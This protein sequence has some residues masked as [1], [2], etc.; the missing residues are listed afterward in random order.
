MGALIARGR[1]V[2]AV[3]LAASVCA[4][5]LVAGAYG[6]FDRHGRETL[7]LGGS[8]DRVLSDRRGGVLLLGSFRGEGAGIVRLRAD[9][10]VD[11]SFAEKGFAEIGWSDAVVRRDGRILVV[12]SG[13][14][15]REPDASDL[16]VTRLRADGTI[17]SSFGEGGMVSVDLGRRL[18]EGTA[19]AMAPK[20]EI[21]IGGSSATT[22]F[23]RGGTDAVGVVGR[24]LPDGELDRRFAGDGL[25][26]V[27]AETVTGLANE[28][29]AG[30]LVA[31][32]GRFPVLEL[33]RLRRGGDLDRSFA[34][35]G[36]LSVRAPETGSLEDYFAPVDHIGML[37][38]GRFVVVGT[39][40]RKTRGHAFG[41]MAARFTADGTLDDSFGSGGYAAA[42]FQG[43][44]F[45]EAF[46]VGRNGGL[47]VAASTIAPESRGH[48]FG[49]I[50]FRPDGRLDR[51]VG[52]AG[53]VVPGFNGNAWARGLAFQSPRRVV[54]AGFLQ[55]RHRPNE[56]V[57]ARVT[58]G[59]SSVR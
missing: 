11:R 43:E 55:A 3:L 1:S 8:V 19:L 54:V 23:Q 2:V 45:P 47:V 13:E 38:S 32:G 20:G 44:T 50:F 51:T 40:S 7:R 16:T 9:G 14:S 48:R 35:E 36:R 39:V 41:M 10:S 33:L 56:T 37:P 26:T 29:D 27:S 15:A 12:G 25:R 52:H 30:V 24:L 57:L 6:A 46:A 34:G 53:K 18:D 59:P 49:L 22:E 5:A 58:L 31:V 21:W 28:P 17:D 4:F 42:D